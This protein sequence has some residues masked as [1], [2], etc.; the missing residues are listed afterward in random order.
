MAE[1]FAHHS[2]A[3]G[4]WQSATGA[5]HRPSVKVLHGPKVSAEE[6]QAF[7][8]DSFVWAID[9]DLDYPIAGQGTYLGVPSY[10]ALCSFGC[11]ARE[12]P[13]RSRLNQLRAALGLGE[14]RY[15]SQWAVEVYYVTPPAPPR[16]P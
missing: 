8:P 10:R 9:R 6:W 12:S 7:W 16:T 3:S 2:E 1:A 5:G 15:A 11:V 14:P 4:L 13:A